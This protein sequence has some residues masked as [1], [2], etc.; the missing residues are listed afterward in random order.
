M[1]IINEAQFVLILEFISSKMFISHRNPLK[2]SV[3][4]ETRV[5]VYPETDETVNILNIKRGIVSAFMVPTVEGRSS[6]MV[7]VC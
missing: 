5:Q 1:R 4:S 6:I 7:S 2:F 3:D